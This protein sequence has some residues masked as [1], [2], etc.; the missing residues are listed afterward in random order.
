MV[1][2]FQTVPIDTGNIYR[3]KMDNTPDVVKFAETVEMRLDMA[4]QRLGQIK[5]QQVAQRRIGAIEVEARLADSD[6][7][8]AV[9]EPFDRL[10]GSLVKTGRAVRVPAH[11]GED[12]LIRLRGRDGIRVRVPASASPAVGRSSGA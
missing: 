11:R 8:R 1:S 5:L 4:K 9:A 2:G 6:D 12:P 7:S 10:R 3:G